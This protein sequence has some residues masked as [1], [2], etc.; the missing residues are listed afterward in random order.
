MPGRPRHPERACGATEPRPKPTP[1][2][3]PPLPLCDRRDHRAAARRGRSVD[4]CSAGVDA[5]DLRADDRL[6]AAARGAATPDYSEPGAW[7]SRPGT[8]ND[9]GGWLPPGVAGTAR[10]DAVVFFVPPTTYL[11]KLHWNAPVRRQDCGRPRARSRASQ[12]SAFSN[13]GRVWAPRY[14]QATAGAFLSAKPDAAHAHSISPM[15]TSR[16]PS[17]RSWRRCRPTRRSFSPAHS[18]GSFHLLRLLR[19]RVAGHAIARR[20]VAAYVVGWPV[21]TTADLPALG[22]TACTTADQTRCLLSWESFGE[23]ADPAQLRV[24]YDASRGFRRLAR[25]GARLRCASTR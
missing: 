1:H 20:I 18:Q 10:T 19:A 23:P 13:V 14:R 11:D 22:M 4:G 9:P 16:A 5:A 3:R 21:S 17:T 25:A 8:P 6:R 15:W 2:G 12:A 24:I 7:L